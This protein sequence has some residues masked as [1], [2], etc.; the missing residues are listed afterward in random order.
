MDVIKYSTTERKAYIT[1]NRPDKRNA[2][3]A[4]LVTELQEAFARAEHDDEVKV[5]ILNAEGKA[6]CAGADLAY[7]QELQQNSYE[8]NLADSNH[9]KVLLLQIYN[10]PK[11][12]IAQVQGPAIAGGCG[13]VTVCDFSYAA[14]E[15]KFGYTEVKIGFVPAMVM[16]FLIR[17]IGE[18][19]ASELLLS[20]ELIGAEQAWKVGMIHKVC[21]SEALADEVNLL[22]DRLIKGNSAASMTLTKKLIKEVQ[23]VSLEE[24]LDQAAKT[25]AQAR[26]TADCQ[27]GISAFLNRE[28]LQW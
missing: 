23:N 13:L 19:R 18:S 3:S 9:L 28:S 8:E 22:A 2:L 4:A 25:N 15:A 16:L 14:R 21:A 26:A 17:K 6:F 1:L 24:A 11:P 27:K 5:I 10:H 20:G 12:V 7:L